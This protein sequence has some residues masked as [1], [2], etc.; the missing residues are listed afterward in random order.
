MAAE[1]WGE[2]AAPRAVSWRNAS[3]TE[4]LDAMRRG[5]HAAFSECYRRFAPMLTRMAAR[6]RVPDGEQAALIAEHLEDTLI[7]ILRGLRREPSPL[8]AYLAAGFRRRLVSVWRAR[9]REAV[10][11]RSLEIVASGRV[12]ANHLVNREEPLENLL[13]VMYDLMSRNGHIKTAI[14]P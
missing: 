10:R 8:G 7:P 14:I 1:S 13:Q 2:E 12:N 9:E 3:E 4:L 11:R 6:R 5:H